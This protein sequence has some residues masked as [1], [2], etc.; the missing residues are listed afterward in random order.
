MIQRA[1]R[2]NA[3]VVLGLA[4]SESN[5][6]SKTLVVDVNERRPRDGKPF[7]PNRIIYELRS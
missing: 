5:L 1:A 6:L 3:F 2:K 4:C 7:W